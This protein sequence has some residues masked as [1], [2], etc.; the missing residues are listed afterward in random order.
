MEG[1]DPRLDA[2]RALNVEPLERGTFSRS[3]PSGSNSD[4]LDPV[5]H[6]DISIR[7]TYEWEDGSLLASVFRAESAAARRF[8]AK[9]TALGQAS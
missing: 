2:E 1:E 5:D 7:K 3:D 4:D 8:D 9:L 6:G